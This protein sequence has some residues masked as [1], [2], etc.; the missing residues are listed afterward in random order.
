MEYHVSKNGSDK[1]PGSINEPFLTISKAAEVA[2]EN[3]FVIV[4]EGVYRECV[5]VTKGGRG[6][7]KRITY[8]AAEGEKAVISGA[9]EITGWEKVSENIWKASVNNTI[10]GDYNPYKETIWGD[11]LRPSTDPALHTGQLY[12][13]GNDMREACYRDQITENKWFCESDEEKTVFYA[14]FGSIDPNSVL[15]EIN[16][17]KYCFKN[18]HNFVNYITVRGFEMCCAATTWSPPTSDQTAALCANWCKGWIIEN[19]TIHH[20]R[21]NG[22]CVGKEV[23]TGHNVK[24][25]Y[26][27]KTGHLSQLEVVFAAAKAGW[28][29]DFVGSHIIRNNHIFECGQAGIVGHMGCAYSE[30]YRNHI[31]HVAYDDEFV[32]AESGGI[33]FHAAIDTYIHHNNIHNSRRGIWLDWQAQGVRV[34]SNLM[35]NNN[36]E[37]VFL[38]VTHGPQMVDNNILCSKRSIINHAQGSAFVNNLLKGG[39]VTNQVIWRYTPYH[40]PHSTEIKNTII[41]Y[42]GDDRFYNNIF[43]GND[44]VLEGAVYGTEMFN[45]SPVSAEEYIKNCDCSDA[46]ARVNIKTPVYINNNA[47]AGN[48]KQFNREE[49]YTTAP[50]VVPVEITEE[51]GKWYLEIDMP[52]SLF[53]KNSEII[54]DKQLP[55]AYFSEADFENPDGSELVID[56][57][58]FGNARGTNPTT[59]PIEGLKSGKQKILVWE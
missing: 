57:D 21:C 47:Y 34:S 35:F 39:L 55:M 42:G 13:N 49:N 30:V 41:V 52:E 25:R 12:I 17:R 59:G 10:F 9:E 31:H 18:A 24:T 48:C 22:I 14:N 54:G 43:T 36:T 50:D 6:N 45:D 33:K 1:N 8:M 58:Y 3:D 15:T 44:N 23:S 2:E 46:D 28:N 4:H 51:D 40:F 29:K 26:Q 7:S 56:K 19:N 27:R 32:G 5:Y 53:V 11:W 16:V 38:E 20:S 37:D